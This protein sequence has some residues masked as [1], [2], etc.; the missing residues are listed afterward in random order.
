MN[1][2]IPQP[3]FRV[4]Q[5]TTTWNSIFPERDGKQIPLPLTLDWSRFMIIVA[6]GDGKAARSLRIT[7][8]V[9]GETAFHIYI[10]E[11]LPGKDCFIYER[12][13]G[14]P[15]DIVLAPRTHKPVLFHVDSVHTIACGEPAPVSIN[16][17]LDGQ[18][19]TLSANASIPLGDTIECSFSPNDQKIHNKTW[20]L[21]SIPKG[22]RAQAQKDADKNNARF[23]A[24][25]YGNYI[26]RA[27][28]TDEGE[29]EGEV[30]LTLSAES[31]QTIIE[32]L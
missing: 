3:G 15:F 18:S 8:I 21:S 22:S 32:S 9:E 4:I 7:R 28:Y 12:K 24:D 30:F 29:R 6:A 25:V 19:V 26:V 10:T 16:C 13:E 27:N 2:S 31:N 17:Y 20:A 23:A 11:T 5:D 14:L 1:P